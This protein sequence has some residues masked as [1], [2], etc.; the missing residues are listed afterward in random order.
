MLAK[1]SGHGPRRLCCR[2]TL[3]SGVRSAEKKTTAKRPL[4]QC[5]RSAEAAL[6]AGCILHTLLHEAPES[7]RTVN[8]DLQVIFRSIADDFPFAQPCFWP[9]VCI[10]AVRSPELHSFRQPDFNLIKASEHVDCS[11][12]VPGIRRKLI[13][14][15]LID[16][17][18]GQ[19]PVIGR[20]NRQSPL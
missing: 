18:T 7:K 9:T 12:E 6:L 1:H 11:V 3:R 15:A 8:D 19:R 13:N 14:L 5:V 17:R 20:Y 10:L 16:Q 2:V 4:Y